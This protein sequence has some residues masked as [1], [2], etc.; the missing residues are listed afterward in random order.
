MNRAAGGYRGDGKTG[1]RDAYVIADQ[2][3]MRRDLRRIR[4]GDEAAI[5]FKLL[6]GRRADLV[7][8]CIRTANRLRGGPRT[9]RPVRRAGP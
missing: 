9:A 3:R 1:A 8:D 4:P 2:P 6:I 5:E 7:E